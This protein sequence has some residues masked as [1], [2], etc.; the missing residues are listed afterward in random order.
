MLGGVLK[1]ACT[2][3]GIKNNE[4]LATRVVADARAFVKWGR[5][6]GRGT[7]GPSKNTEEGTRQYNCT[8]N[9]ANASECPNNWCR[10]TAM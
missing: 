3:I 6:Y 1:N 7:R 2:S 9:D 8:K 4:N 5:G 10:F